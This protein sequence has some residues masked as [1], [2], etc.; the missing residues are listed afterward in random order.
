MGFPSDFFPVLFAIPRVAGWL[1]HWV[2]SLSAG[3]DGAPRIW[4]PRQVYVGPSRR[5]YVSV[6]ERADNGVGVAPD[7]S[8]PHHAFN[9]RFLAS[10]L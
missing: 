2:E 8:V 7:L 3:L 1:A 6:D 10:K 4:R 5:P 9:R